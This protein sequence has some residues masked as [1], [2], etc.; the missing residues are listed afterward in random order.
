MSRRLKKETQE[1]QE[2]VLEAFN[3]QD[4][5]QKGGW[6][7]RAEV[8]HVCTTFAVVAAAVVAPRGS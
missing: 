3:L 5:L 6:Y 7:I 8:P 1:V 2:E 4:G